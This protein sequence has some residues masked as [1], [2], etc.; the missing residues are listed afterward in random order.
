MK[1]LLLFS[2]LLTGTQVYAQGSQG[3]KAPEVVRMAFCKVFPGVNDVKW[4]KEK[5][6]YE[7]NF[8]QD[9]QKTSA[10]FDKDA[11]GWRQSGPLPLPHCQRKQP[12]I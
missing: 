1:K 2:L 10:T 11:N 9:G 5:G 4:E 7:A 6:V 3:A 12:L 8:R